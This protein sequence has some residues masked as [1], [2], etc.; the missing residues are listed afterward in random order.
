MKKLTKFH[1][2]LIAIGAV[3]LVAAVCFGVYMFQSNKEKQQNPTT[4]LSFT[5]EEQNAIRGVKSKAS[6]AFAAEKGGANAKEA[7]LMT[8]AEDLSAINP[9][10]SVKYGVGGDACVVTVK[11][12]KHT[13]DMDA[14]FTQR[15]DGTPYA[16]TAR[17]FFYT[18]LTGSDQ[19]A[20]NEALKGFNLDGDMVTQAGYAY[21]FD[22]IDK[23]NLEYVYIQNQHDKLTFIELNGSFY[24]TESELD[25]DTATT[26]T[27]I[28]AARA[29]VA[30]DTVKDPENLEKY[31]LK[32]NAKATAIVIAKVKDGDSFSIIIGNELPD[33]SGYYAKT[34][35]K[36]RIYV[37]QSNIAN[38][39]LVPKESFLV[40]NFGTSMN[41]V[42]EPF[43]TVT[44]IRI[45]FDDGDVFKAQLMSDK[46]KETHNNSSI[47][48][49]WKVTA[50][51]RFISGD[52][53]YALPNPDNIAVCIYTLSHLAS[54][55]VV[56][57]DINDET[58]AEYGLDKPYRVFS[59]LY[60]GQTRI[61]TSFSKPN[62]DDICYVYSV[63]ENVSDGKKVKI[64]I[65]AIE[66]DSFEY[67]HYKAFN[68][69]SNILY[70]GYL[71]NLDSVTISRDGK[72]YVMTFTKDEIGAL[73]A[74]KVNG[75]DADLA[76][77]QAFYTR[78]I[79]C[80]VLDE[81]TAEEE[82]PKELIKVSINKGGEITSMS[83][84]RI[85]NMKAY[86]L[87]NNKTA[88]YISYNDLEKLISAA[89]AI[90]AGETVK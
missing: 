29:P 48:Y 55:E 66:A 54:D 47:N 22:P 1:K 9:K 7:F 46:E 59:W 81:Y 80:K 20:P 16:S 78:F 37:M 27:M 72:D 8:L 86:G 82:P 52:N 53:G 10:I 49:A 11:G 42:K 56:E 83:F 62:D 75:V 13:A 17:A 4:T 19:G 71:K 70:S 45:E 85:S 5:K 35:A 50:P 69:T 58:L 23:A 31:G 40:A 88:L 2:Q 43:D 76:S 67:L 39:L 25:L 28:A 6:V 89:D 90:I 77:C 64:G 63:K 33:G 41:D 32:D 34:P 65:A 26:A 84:G 87:V 44:D 18:A 60:K 14:L 51:D 61:T 57:S 24:L 36:D 12:D 38:Y 15:E 74:A 30:I 68:Y 21:L 79:S 73:T 3:V